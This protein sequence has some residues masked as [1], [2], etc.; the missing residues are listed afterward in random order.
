MSR[1]NYHCH[2]QCS[3]RLISVAFYIAYMQCT[4]WV[5]FFPTA[6]IKDWQ[7]FLLCWPHCFGTDVLL[8]NGFFI[9]C[10]VAL[11]WTKQILHIYTRKDKSACKTPLKVKLRMQSAKEKRFWEIKPNRRAGE[12][13]KREQ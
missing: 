4:K 12:R 3:L 5:C 1:G 6:T 10:F 9:R 2:L 11:W 7:T 13:V 8:C